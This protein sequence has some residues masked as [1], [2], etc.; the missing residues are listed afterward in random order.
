MCSIRSVG[1]TRVV[2]G[3]GCRYLKKPIGSVDK[4]N[5]AAKRQILD[6]ETEMGKE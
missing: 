2:T 1:T 6:T 5:N 3:R 4:K